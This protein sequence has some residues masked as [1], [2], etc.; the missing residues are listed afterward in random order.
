MIELN[1]ADGAESITIIDKNRNLII[2]NTASNDITITAGENM[3]L[4]AKNMQINVEEDLDISVG[5]NKSENVSGDS[6]ITAKNEDKQV[7]EVIKVISSEYKQEA[8]EIATDAS[9]EIKTNAG[10]KI[11]IASAESIEYGE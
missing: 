10:G 7:G 4:N 3:T 1:D 9:G 8:Q 2:I 6:L 5:K 11:S